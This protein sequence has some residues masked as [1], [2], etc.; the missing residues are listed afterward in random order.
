[1]IYPVVLCGGHGSRLWPVSR[2]AFPK[3]FVQLHGEGSLFQ[4]AVLRNSGHGFK[5]PVVIT[6][7]KFRFTVAGQ[8][9]DIEITP[10]VLI[11]EPEAR[12]TAPAILVA[13]LWAVLQ[14]PEAMILV[15][16]SD[17]VITDTEAFRAAVFA[18]RHEAH[19][20]RIVTFGIR[21]DRAETG[22]GYLEVGESFGGVCLA[23]NRFVEKP[24]LAAAE[25]MLLS[26][27]HLWNAGIFLFRADVMIAAYE[28][29][30]PEILV[31]VRAALDNAKS[32]LDF[33]RL[34]PQ[35]WVKLPD[36]SIDYAIMERADNLCVMPY[37][38]KW[39]DLGSWAAVA[40]Q[41]MDQLDAAGNMVSSHSLAVDCKNTLLRSHDACLRLVGI[42]LEDMVAIATEDAVLVAPKDQTQRVRDVVEILKKMDAKEATQFQHDFRPWGS[43]KSL[44][45]G[46]RFQVKR[47]VVLPGGVLSLQSHQYRAEHWIVVEGVAKV[48]IDLETKV[49]GENQSVYVPCGSVHRLENPSQSPVVLIEVQTGSY[50]G[51]DDIVRY[52]DIY[53]RS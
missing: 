53:N 27:D 11:L 44:A 38:G 3:Q 15:A 51:E 24:S 26:G 20:G 29:Y 45:V 2:A 47:I 7:D 5:A 17:H 48:T 30:A 42:G 13:S 16:P 12:N 19:A 36:I 25:A 52:E 46:S 9:Q 18:A 28:A 22:F 21:P 23:L 31:H 4:Q 32:D 43:F 8:M 1:M 49:V 40:E 50:F 6:S 10:Q 33:L 39:S 35:A 14:N 41:S 34:D 37:A